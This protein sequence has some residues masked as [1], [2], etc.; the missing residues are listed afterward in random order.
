MGW[1]SP[2]PCG[3]IEALLMHGGGAASFS[4]HGYTQ[5]LL[6]VAGAQ[7][8]AF[9][10]FLALLNAHGKEASLIVACRH[11]KYICLL[12]P[13][14]TGYVREA[15]VWMVVSMQGWVWLSPCPYWLS[16]R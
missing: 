1:A 4:L 2:D 12:L 5:T 15:S 10:I 13:E 8:H 3:Y 16:I 7:R 14:H 11:M 9:L 6:M